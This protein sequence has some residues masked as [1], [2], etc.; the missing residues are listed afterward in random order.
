MKIKKLLA[1]V[2]ASVMVIAMMP[3]M[4]M[5][6]HAEES[7]AR[8]DC[9][10]GSEDHIEGNGACYICTCNGFQASTP[11]HTCSNETISG[12][13][14]AEPPTCTEDGWYGY[15]ECT[16]GKK[17][18]EPGAMSEITDFDAWKIGAGKNP[19]EGHNWANEDGICANYCGFEC[20]HGG[21]AT[22]DVCS[23]C[24][25][26]LGGG[27]G[28]SAVQCTDKLYGGAEGDC[29]RGELKDSFDNFCA[30][31]CTTHEDGKIEISHEGKTSCECGW[32]T[33]GG[34]SCEPEAP[35]P[36]PSVSKEPSPSPSP[37]PVVEEKKAEAPAAE[38]APSEPAEETPVVDETKL[39][40]EL[41]AKDTTAVTAAISSVVPGATTY[42]L[43][44]FKTTKG[45]ALGID[46]AVKAEQKKNFVA[47][48]PTSQVEI[49]TGQ[50]QTFGK[51]CI[52]VL[53]NSNVA[54]VYSFMHKGHLY[55]VTIP[56]GTDITNLLDKHG[57]AGP[58]YIGKALGTTVLV[59]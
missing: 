15:Y 20:N 12:P 50:P 45:F 57:F 59:K 51:D 39:P 23:I 8:E 25:K 36:A 43:S 9:G 38:P 49:F 26:N 29:A 10:H 1:S 11:T 14:G 5:V 17:Y 52:A 40:V 33:G 32:T 58:L 47:A 6:A 19:A 41:V 44:Q 55:R 4:S 16:C 35:A 24:G 28:S 27:S 18:A 37:S 30:W 53:K 13:T 46:K 2:I 34:G 3:N 22:T 56:A 42:N 31:A 7:C 54:V 48:V 21:S